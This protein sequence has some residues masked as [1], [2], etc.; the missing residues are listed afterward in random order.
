MK[1]K[2]LSL[3]AIKDKLLR[4]LVSHSAASL[5]DTYV[6]EF[7]DG[8]ALSADGYVELRKKVAKQSRS[9]LLLVHL[10]R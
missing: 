1:A 6:E 5:F 10:K 3:K 9:S 7:Y 8:E 2:P 4:L